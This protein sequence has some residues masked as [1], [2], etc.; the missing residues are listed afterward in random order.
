MESRVARYGAALRPSERERACSDKAG[1]GHRR[2]ARAKGPVSELAG[3]VQ[4]PAAHLAV[5]SY[6]A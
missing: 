5:R 1:D 2:V 6:R 4:T 3:V